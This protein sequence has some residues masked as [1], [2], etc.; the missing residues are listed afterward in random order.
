[1]PSTTIAVSV[2]RYVTDCNEVRRLCVAARQH[3]L[4]HGGDYTEARHLRLLSD[5][6]EMCAIS[7]DFMLRYSTSTS[8]CASACAQVCYQCAV[9]CARW[10][11]DPVMDAC[12]DACARFGMLCQEIAAHVGSDALAVMD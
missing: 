2:D 7:T 4:A 8:W 1:M 12:A 10:R 5:C 6:E 9:S 3:A 11:Q